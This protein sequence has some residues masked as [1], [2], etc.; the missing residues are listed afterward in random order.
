[1]QHAN[2]LGE[3]VLMLAYAANRPVAG[4][5]PSSPPAMLLIISAHVALIALVMSARMEFQPKTPDRT[6]VVNVPIV[7]VPPPNPV[8]HQPQRSPA[9]QPLSDPT[10]TVPLPRPDPVQLDPGRVDPGVAVGGSGLNTI[11]QF[12]TQ[13]IAPVRHDAQ[14]LTR[15]DDLKP[16]YP[17]SKILSGEEAT[18][19]LRL[20]ISDTGRVTAVDAIG[21]ADRVFLEAAR[22]YLIGHWR[23]RPATEDGRAITSST[24]ISLRFQLD[25]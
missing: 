7:P 25:G 14:L 3:E 21:A 8:A 22:R 2:H 10:P 5:R 13:L 16:P 18:L 9:P 17:E 1:M 4:K 15:P 6:K 23:Y 24:V 12:P 11:P 20:T 19:H